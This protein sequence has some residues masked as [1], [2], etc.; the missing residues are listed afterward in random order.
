MKTAFTEVKPYHAGLVSGWETTQDNTTCGHKHMGSKI[1]FE[2][3]KMW[4]KQAT[5]QL[6]FCKPASC[7]TN[8]D[9]KVNVLIHSF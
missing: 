6:L 9:A 2:R 4:T 3:S 5:D 8:T 1:L 7:K